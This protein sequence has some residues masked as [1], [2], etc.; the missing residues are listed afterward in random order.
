MNESQV[1]VP[2]SV[3]LRFGHAAVQHLAEQVGV[4]V[5]HIKGAAVD[6]ELRPMT[7]GGTDV[8]VLVRPDDVARFDRALREH[9]WQL[10]STFEFGSPFGHAQTYLHDAWGYLDIHRFFPG[11]RVSPSRA[12]D[13]MWADRDTIPIAGVGCPVPSIPAQALLLI[14]N[15]GRSREQDRRDIRLAWRDASDER[16]AEI[17]ALVAELDAPVAFA[18]AV[19]GLERYRDERDYRLWRVVSQGGSRTEEWWARVRAAPTLSEAVR[20]VARAPLVNVG[21]LAHKLGRRPTRLEVVGE[22]FARPVRAV[23]EA[24]RVLWRRGAG[25]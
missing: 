5:L 8:D 24:G 25:S 4:D 19:G 21:H 6:P 20:V 23:G 22:F 3:R 17:E 16:R 11:I 14:L 9:G 7:L 15:A 10:Y 12:F 13:R 2:L 1:S 18:A